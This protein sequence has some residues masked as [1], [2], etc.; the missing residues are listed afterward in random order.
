MITQARWEVW[1]TNSSTN[2][3]IAIY[4][5][6]QEYIFDYDEVLEFKELPEDIYCSRKTYFDFE[7]KANILYSMIRQIEY[8]G[9]CATKYHD[10]YN[11]EL[12][13]EKS[14]LFR[15]KFF[16]VLDDFE[17]KYD[18]SKHE[19]KD[20]ECDIFGMSGICDMT[21]F[22]TDTHALEAFL[23][24]PRSGFTFGEENNWPSYKF[25]GYTNMSTGGDARIYDVFLI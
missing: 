7:T 13:R 10:A 4:N 11:A 16:E 5:M 19:G 14:E 18:E 9:K 1:E 17:I 8:E 24:D 3:Q 23:F 22:F 15:Q 20:S 12:F 6:Q 25:V 21:S 2:N